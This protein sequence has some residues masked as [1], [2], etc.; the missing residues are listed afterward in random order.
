MNMSRKVN[1]YFLAR[2]VSSWQEAKLLCSETNWKVLETLRDVGV[3]G[4]SAEEISKRIGVPKSSIYNILNKLEAANWVDSSTRRLHWGRPLKEAKRRFGGKPTKVFIAKMWDI[5]ECEE[6][7]ANS[8]D[9]VLSTMGKETDELK[10][11]WVSILE[12]ITLAYQT[13]DLKKFFPQDRIHED[14]GFSHE[15]VEFLYAISSELLRKI[16]E[17]EKFNEFG[18][19][20]KFVK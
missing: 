18:R 13:N 20:Y 19:K 3:D 17:D 5:G 1:K 14:C 16:L 6:D 2:P 8:I 10:E 11:K 12:K 9:G 15:G 4:L 7:F